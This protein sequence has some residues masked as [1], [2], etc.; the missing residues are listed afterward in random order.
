MCTILIV[1]FHTVIIHME[2]VLMPGV[3]LNAIAICNLQHFSQAVGNAF[4][5]E[6]MKEGRVQHAS[7]AFVNRIW[8]V[9]VGSFW[10]GGTYYFGSSAEYMS[11]A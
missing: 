8:S 7:I 5:F 10:S 3:T 6:W 11:P 9:M 1:H 4:Q 2:P